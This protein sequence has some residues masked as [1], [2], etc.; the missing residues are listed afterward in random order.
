[1][2]KQ[3]LTI[4]VTILSVYSSVG[5]EFIDNSG[6]PVNGSDVIKLKNSHYYEKRGTKSATIINSIPSPV[7]GI[8]DIAYDGQYLWVEGYNAFNLYQI[9]PISGSV[10]RTIP[11]NVSYPKGLTFDGNYLW[12]SDADNLIIQKIDTANGNVLQTFPTPTSPSQSF[13]GGLAWDGVNLWFNDDKDGSCSFP[14][15]STFKLNTSGQ[16]LQAFNAVS[17]CP[18]GLTFD[19]QYLWSSDNANDEIYKIDVSTFLVIETID[20][21]GGNYPNGL[22]FDGQ[23]L[24][25]SNNDADSIYQIDIG[26]TPTGFSN[27][28]TTLNQLIIYPNPASNQITIISEQLAI[29][30]I[31][32]FSISGKIIKSFQEN[33]RT[34]NIADFPNGIYF[35]QLVT[36]DKK[37]NKKFIKQ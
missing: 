2:K 26:F 5:Q 22:A 32:I 11:T 19:G 9:S 37:I 28:N 21:P 4:I 34:I 36:D 23:Y 35:I 16:T 8:N 12:L 20:A 17:S 7:S 6:N 33:T 13:P 24:W 18:K 1:M 30:E 31:N 14:G 15:D 10:I 29:I 3:I 27:S 25:V